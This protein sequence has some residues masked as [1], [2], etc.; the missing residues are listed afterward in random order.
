[1]VGAHHCLPVHE[2]KRPTGSEPAARGDLSGNESDG[3]GDPA[4]IVREPTRAIAATSPRPRGIYSRE[5]EI[6]HDRLHPDGQL[7]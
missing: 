7:G 6:Q 4:V 1:M 2:E 5:R 3:R